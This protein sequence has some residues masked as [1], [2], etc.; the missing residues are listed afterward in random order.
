MPVNNSLSSVMSDPV[1]RP[2]L[3][4]HDSLQSLEHG[5]EIAQR[6]RFGST[7]AQLSDLRPDHPHVPNEN[8]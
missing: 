6:H 5:K 7:L 8:K 3:R 1:N 4:F 2:D